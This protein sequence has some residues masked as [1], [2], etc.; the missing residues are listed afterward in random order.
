MTAPIPG[1]A[2]QSVS[3]VDESVSMLDGPAASSDVDGETSR[4]ENEKSGAQPSNSK[5]KKGSGKG[6]SLMAQHVDA[7]KKSAELVAQT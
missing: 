4:L 3:M 7:K 5:R 6:V 2:D 1:A